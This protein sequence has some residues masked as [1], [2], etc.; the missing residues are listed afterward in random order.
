[1]AQA[2]G[3]VSAYVLFGSPSGATADWHETTSWEIAA[4]IPDVTVIED[5]DGE[6]AG[7]FGA[8]TSG[9][10]LLYDAA[11]Q[12]QFS[13]GITDARGH[14]GDNVG[15]AAIVALLLTGASGHSRSSVFGCPLVGTDNPEERETA[16]GQ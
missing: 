8:A 15:R 3:R 14:A 4:A 12:L 11:G 2:Q 5:A 16:W 10:T 1:M 13:G 9:Q 7:R 6:E